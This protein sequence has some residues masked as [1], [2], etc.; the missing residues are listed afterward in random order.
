MRNAFPVGA[1][2]IK[3]ARALMRR[4]LNNAPPSS[5]RRWSLAGHLLGYLAN[6][7]SD[8]DGFPGPKSI[9]LLTGAED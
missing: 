5:Y 9:A 4:K 3:G 6:N 2:L 7:R 8:Y 1:R